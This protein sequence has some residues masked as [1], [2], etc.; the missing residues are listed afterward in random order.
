MRHVCIQHQRHSSTHPSHTYYSL[1]HISVA[2][3]LS[4]LYR[5]ASTHSHQHPTLYMLIYN[6]RPRKHVHVNTHTYVDTG[7]STT[8]AGVI[9]TKSFLYLLYI[10]YPF[11][12]ETSIIYVYSGIVSQYIKFNP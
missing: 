5:L 1:Y 8:Q 11:E 6:A 12:C 4:S 2:P 3:S 10:I 7:V 9:V